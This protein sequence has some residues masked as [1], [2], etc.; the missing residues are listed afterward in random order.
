MQNREAFLRKFLAPPRKEHTRG[1]SIMKQKFKVTIVGMTCDGCARHVEKELSSIGAKAKIDDWS[2]GE[3]VVEADADMAQASE[4][5]NKALEKTNYKITNVQPVLSAAAKEHT[6]VNQNFSTDLIVIGTGGA[7][8]GAAIEAANMGKKVTIIERGEVVGGTC[9]NVGCVPSKEFVHTA[10][11]IHAIQNLHQAGIKSGSVKVDY[12]V[13]VRERKKL[14]ESLRHEKYENVLGSYPNI[15]LIHGEA[16]FET[17]DTGVKVSVST[18]E[19]G[20]ELLSAEK[21]V[22]ATGSR[23]KMPEIEGLAEAAPWNSTDALFAEKL[24]QSLLIIGGGFIAL[25]LGQSF[26]RL[27][28]EVTI[29]ARSRLLSKWDSELSGVIKERLEAEG[30]QVFEKCR[31]R[32]VEREKKNVALF[33]ETPKGESKATGEEILVATGRTGNMENLSLENAGVLQ[34]VAAGIIP[35]NENMLTSNPNIAAAGDVT[36]HPK[37]VYVAAKAGKLASRNLFGQAEKFETNILPE[38][39]FTEPEIARVGLTEEEAKEEGIETQ[40]SKLPLEAV[41]RAIASR[42]TAGFIK[43]VA[44]KATGKLIGAHVIS[45]HAGDI[46]HIASMAIRLGKTSGY[47]VDDLKNEF[48]AYLTEAEGIKLAVQTFHMDISKLSC[49]AG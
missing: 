25:E 43:L 27:G 26:A 38:V 20:S 2:K 18:K 41:P 11:K 19:G 13:L 33:Y 8:M 48:F 17:S 12:P 34:D 15:R 35:V 22:I 1:E 37:L 46:I 23:P 6:A 14:V 10:R 47:T 45:P 36:Q 21:A 28:V 5:F 42:S 32:H 44:E 29:F 39:I 7:G 24:P 31:F 16:H 40:V 3:A 4:Q 9:V 49:C 30:I